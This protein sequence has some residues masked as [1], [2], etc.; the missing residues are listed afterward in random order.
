VYCPKCNAEYIE[1][2][3][4]CADC[5]VPLVAELPDERA[6]SQPETAEFK[7]ILTTFN[8][9]DIAIIKSLLDEE[10]IDY[11]FQG[12]LC[13]YA[14]LLM[15]PVRLMVRNDQVGEAK[16]ILKDLELDYSLNAAV[17]E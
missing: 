8:A 2:I 16:D 13:N 14:R 9:G 6:T 5:G 17:E 4:L 1:G 7:E 15:E 11:Y 12:E 10:S 3:T